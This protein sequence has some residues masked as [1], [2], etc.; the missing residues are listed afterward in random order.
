MK[1]LFRNRHFQNLLFVLAIAV[2]ML[3]S[4]A[5]RAQAWNKV[6][7]K[8][9]GIVIP[10]VGLTE[11]GKYP[12]Y[13]LHP[14]KELTAFQADGYTFTVVE[15]PQYMVRVAEADV[16]ANGYKCTGYCVDKFGNIVGL[17]PKYFPVK[18]WDGYTIQPID[19]DGKYYVYP[20]LGNLDDLN[21][22]YRGKMYKPADIMKS[23][24]AIS[25]CDNGKNGYTCEFLCANKAG[26]IVG[27]NPNYARAPGTGPA[28]CTK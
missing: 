22:S 12:I 27:W 7:D 4:T 21:W 1:S 23:M 2:A 9:M 24:P 13:L 15:L 5:C 25:P 11:D 28:V 17:N 3:A 10:V 19:N 16:N 20:K 8:N 14:N 26:G 18:K 6:T